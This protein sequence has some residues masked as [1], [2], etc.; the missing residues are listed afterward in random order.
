MR[1]LAPAHALSRSGSA[2]TP[3]AILMPGSGWK[4][5]SPSEAAVKGSPGKYLTFS[6]FSL[7]SSVSFRPSY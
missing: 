3:E 4:G 5:S 2:L 1:A 7:K 6:F